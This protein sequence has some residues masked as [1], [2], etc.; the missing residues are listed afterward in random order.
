V[1]QRDR[2]LAK[3]LEWDT[4]AEHVCAYADSEA[5]I[6]TLA[7]IINDLAVLARKGPA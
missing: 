3:R 4:E 2:E 6:R 7:S 5:D 1:K